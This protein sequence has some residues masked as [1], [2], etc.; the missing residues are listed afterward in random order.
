MLSSFLLVP[1][2]LT[3]RVLLTL[4][5]S[6]SKG[7]ALCLVH[8]CVSEGEVDVTQSQLSSHQVNP[9]NSK[10]TSPFYNWSTPAGSNRLPHLTSS[11]AQL[12][13]I[14]NLGS[15]SQFF[16]FF[17]FHS[18]VR[19]TFLI[20]GESILFLLTAQV[21][22]VLGSSCHHS[23]CQHLVNSPSKYLWDPTF[24][25]QHPQ[26]Q[27]ATFYPLFLIW[28]LDWNAPQA[29]VLNACSPA[30]AHILRDCEV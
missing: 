4:T 1:S 17:F 29:H 19:A 18:V 2:L 9:Q 11:T 25:S 13:D 16:V 14:S 15:S 22:T 21:K 5:P 24:P 30:G 10:S 27:H 26:Y 6:C 23:N 20:S 8:T 7:S 28:Q 3:Q 12:S